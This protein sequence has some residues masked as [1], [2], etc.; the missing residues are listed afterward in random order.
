M[1]IEDDIRY[2]IVL[3]SVGIGRDNV[4]RWNLTVSGTCY[5]GLCSHQV[6][7]VLADYMGPADFNISVPCKFC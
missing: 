4:E 5:E 1:V 6:Q 7:A 2:E 3:E